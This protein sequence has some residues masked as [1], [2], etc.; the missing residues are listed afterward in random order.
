[1][2]PCKMGKTAGRRLRGG[3]PAATRLFDWCGAPRP[4]PMQG[5]SGAEYRIPDQSRIECF[6]FYPTGYDRR[7]SKPAR[8]DHSHQIF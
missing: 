8:H 3:L 1:M 7:V 6:P 5:L 4:L 2:A